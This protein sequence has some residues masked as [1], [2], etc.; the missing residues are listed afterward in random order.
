M[1]FGSCHKLEPLPAGKKTMWRR[2]MDYLLSVCDYIVEFYPSSQTLPDGTKVEVMATKPR[3]GIYINLPALE[4]LDAMLTEILDSFQKAEFWY[5]DAGT[6]SFGSATSSSTMSSSSFQRSTHR[7]EDKWWL[8]VPCVPDAG[9]FGKARKGLQ[10]KRGCTAR[11]RSRG[12]REE[13]ERG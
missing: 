12:E 13:G 3:S 6:R 10:Q 9:I 7:N 4:K 1:V 5:A 8:P 11:R 2:E